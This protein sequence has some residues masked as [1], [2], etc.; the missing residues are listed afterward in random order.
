MKNSGHLK[1]YTV[2]AVSLFLISPLIALP[3]IVWGIY[4]QERSAYFLFSLFLGLLAWLQIPFADLFRHSI[5]A[6]SYYGKPISYVFENNLSSDYFIPIISWLLINNDIPYQLLRFLYVTES[7]FLMTI[8]FNYMIV[9]S[10]KVYTNAE[11]FTRFCILFFFFEFIKTTCGVRY[12]FALYQ[13]IFALH[14]AFNKQSYV[15]ALLFACLSSLIHVSFA[16][17]IPVSIILYF[18]CTSLKKS[19]IIFIVFSSVI[20]AVLSKYGYLL[21]RR[22]DWYFAGG[23]S[24]SDNAINVI[25]IYGFILFVAIR[26]FL[27]PYMVLAIR[28]FG[29]YSYWCRIS[30]V[31]IG[32]SIV[33]ITNLTILAR[34]TFIL[35]ALGI[36]LLLEIESRTIIQQR[37]IN[38]I[39]WC[40]IMT[41]LFNAVNYRTYIFNSRYQYIAMPLPLILNNQYDK[42]WILENVDGNNMKN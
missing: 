13:Y 35:S 40:G 27:L 18:I 32:L 38:L 6:Y 9:K 42:Q 10:D 12:G 15:G 25:T 26:F 22:A 41:T 30:I 24:T 29:K 8:V 19:A 4:R 23:S 31:W 7:F 34:T 1:I 16:F 28:Y 21:G 36:F 11:V 17:F 20:L 33:F 39:L 5:T 37:I 2:T 3:Y 14:L